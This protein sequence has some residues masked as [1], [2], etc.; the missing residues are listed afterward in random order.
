MSTLN[1]SERLVAAREAKGLSQKE[2]AESLGMK[3]PSYN[4]YEHGREMKASMIVKVC[5][6][7]ECS[8]GWLVGAEEE[9]QHLPP[10]SPLLKRL[11]EAFNELNNKG[12]KKVVGYAEDLTGNV[13]YTLTVK[14][15]AANS[16]GVSETVEGVA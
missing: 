3:Q 2:M 7:L 12:Q 13:E 10:E 9:G 14:K 1:F 15:E 11:K 16:E 6:I 4:Y 5:A 8:P